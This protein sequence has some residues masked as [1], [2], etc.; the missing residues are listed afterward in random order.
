MCVGDTRHRR[1]KKGLLPG[2]KGRRQAFLGPKAPHMPPTRIWALSYRPRG[3]TSLSLI[4]PGNSSCLDLA[5]GN[6]G[7]RTWRGLLQLP[8]GLGGGCGFFQGEETD[9][10][11]LALPMAP[12]SFS[13]LT[14]RSLRTLCDLLESGDLF[15]SY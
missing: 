1:Q 3:K 11:F 2:I 10:A 9:L 12:I 15:L 14:A 5:L 4:P 6:W 8:R 13:E 7:P